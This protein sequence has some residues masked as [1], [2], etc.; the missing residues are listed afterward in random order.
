[1]RPLVA[2]VEARPET[3]DDDYRR[4]LTLAGLDAGRVKSLRS[5]RM[6]GD[7]V[8]A[9]TELL[10]REALLTDESTP[11]PVWVESVLP[12]LNW[13]DAGGGRSVHPLASG[14]EA[15]SAM[16]DD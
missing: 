6:Q 5:A 12:S 2:L 13:Q 9:L 1:M 3:V 11:A 8:A 4:A 10:T 15:L 7:A 16:L 14:R